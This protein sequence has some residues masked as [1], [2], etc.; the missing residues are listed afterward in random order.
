MFIVQII[1]FVCLALGILLG[2]HYFLYFS[3][4]RFF[5]IGTAVYKNI[6]MGVL[7]FLSVSFILGSFLARWQENIFSRF[8]YFASGF[9]VGLL[10]NLIMAVVF[11]W[12]IVWVGRLVDF[13]PSRALLGALF[14]AGAL[15]ISVYGVYNAFDVKIKN[16]TVTIP[17]LPQEWK[18][19]KIVQIS[20]LHLGFI[21]KSAF[22]ERV[23]EKINAVSP[24]AVVITGDL[25]DGMDG[26]LDLLV[27]PLGEITVPRGVYFVTGNHETYLGVKECFEALEKVKI[28]ILRD[29][30]VDLGGLKIIGIGYPDRNETKDIVTTAQS[31]QK[32]FYGQPN[33]LLYHSPV[34]TEQFKKAG[35]NLQ[36]AGHTHQGQIFPINYITNLIYRG[37]GYG[38]HQLGEYAIYITSGA[39]TWGPPLRIGTSSEIVVIVLQ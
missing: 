7:A 11:I 39:G 37:Y 6:L 18:N 2:A 30:V 12:L 24:E 34:R 15:G 20:D 16:I 4:I 10:L 5:S 14:F 26:K 36:L 3:I 28:N 25:F 29:E 27:V 17:G 21:N 35:V 8:F 22:M 9:C 1:I 31:L 33:I 32:Y 38:L 13:K 23:V 19:K